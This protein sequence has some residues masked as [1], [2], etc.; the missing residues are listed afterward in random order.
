MTG[1][2]ELL[3]RDIAAVT[4][5]IIVTDSELLEAR[6]AV[7]ERIARQRSRGRL[8]AAVAAAAAVVVLGAAGLGAFLVLGDD[9]DKASQPSNPGPEIIDPDADYLTGKAP[10]PQILKGLWRLDNGEVLVK[11]DDN[12]TVSFDEQGTVFSRP[13]TS[14]TYTIAGNVITVTTTNDAQ[15]NCV[16]TTYAL[17]AVL[18]NDSNLR[19]I[20]SPATPGPCAPLPVGRGAL[21]HVLP[22]GPAVTGLVFSGDPGWGPLTV[23]ESLYGVWTAERGGYVLEIDANGAYYV[24]NETAEPVDRGTWSLNGRDLTFTS[25]AQST[26]CTAGDQLVLAGVGYEHPNTSAF[27]GTVQKNTCSAPWTPTA[28]IL[29]PNVNG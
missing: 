13:V 25:S 23:K 11:F 20:P 26:A 15:A 5:G 16:G 14:G 24:A 6:R 8:S 29:L 12:G 9:D 17:R 3:T 27:R 1:I 28:W 18:D 2:E 10:T 22:A 7:N 19:F 4:R 21:E